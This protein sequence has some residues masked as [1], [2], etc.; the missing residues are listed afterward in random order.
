VTLT[1]VGPI[2]Q[3]LLMDGGVPPATTSTWEL[4]ATNS[5]QAGVTPYQFTVTFP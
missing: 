5:L 4:R 3:T 1:L 2:A